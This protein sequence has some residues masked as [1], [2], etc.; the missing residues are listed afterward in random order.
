LTAFTWV[1]HGAAKLGEFG[2]ATGG[3]HL[4]I[5]LKS[6]EKLE[7]RFGGVSRLGSPY[8]SVLLKGEPWIFEF[9]PDLYASMQFCLTIPP[10]P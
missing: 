2:F 5:E 7:V 1:G 6:G 8:A 3:Y 9:P 4:A 10:S